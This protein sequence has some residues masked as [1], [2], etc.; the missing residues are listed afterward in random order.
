MSDAVKQLFVSV[1]YTLRE[2]IAA[3]DKT[4]KGIVLVVDGRQRLL[5]TVT[6][7]DIRRAILAGEDLSL[8]VQKLLERRASALYPQ[9]VTAPVGMPDAELLRLMNEHTIRQIPLLDDH[10]RVVDIALLNDLVKEYELPLTAVVMAGGYGTRLRP[11]TEDTP[12]PLLP[13][14]DRPLMEHIMDQLRKAGI[15]HVKIATNFMHEKIKEHFGDGRE[16]GVDIDYITEDRPMGTAGALSLMK[17]PEQP[18]LVINGDILT[19]VDFRAMLAFHRE[20]DADLT[21]GV[22]QYDL[23][24]PYG[25]I[26]SDGVY[27]K[28]IREKPLYTFFI[29]AGIYLL[30]PR[31]YR[32]IPIEKHFDMTDLIERLIAEGRSVVNFPIIEYWL[33]IGCTEDY[34]QAQKDLEERR[35]KS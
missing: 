19:G 25:V 34:E 2:C 21:V 35:G 23:K 5:D 1:T 9:P 28:Q 10:R 32:F 33:D 16:F 17:T 30:E 31:A 24:V 12:K 4:G 27:I 29:N 11:L 3:I 7:G 26:E 13:V 22:R 20:H 8:S 14:G 18:M 15:Q 6:D